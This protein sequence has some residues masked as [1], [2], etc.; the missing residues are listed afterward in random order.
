VQTFNLT[1]SVG[2]LAAS[3]PSN[4]WA[5]VGPTAQVTVTTTQRITGTVTAALGHSAAGTPT[6]NYAICAI[7]GTSTVQPPTGAS[8]VQQLATYLTVVMPADTAARMPYTVSGS[9]TGGELGGAATYRV[10]LCTNQSAAINNN[11]FITG[12]I[13]VTN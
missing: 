5:F 13:Q 1:G 8:G 6:L 7:P 9:K 10:G 4:A 3:S 12:Y 2:S 11:D